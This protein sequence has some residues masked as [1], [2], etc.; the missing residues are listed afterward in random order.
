MKSDKGVI[1]IAVT[2][3]NNFVA[4]EGA[5]ALCEAVG[6]PALGDGIQDG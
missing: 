1:Y 5:V 6:L 3:F 4:A 2:F